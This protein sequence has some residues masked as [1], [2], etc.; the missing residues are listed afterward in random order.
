M[1][2]WNSR[3]L[4]APEWVLEFRF[5]Y[6]IENHMLFRRITDLDN[7]ELV[8]WKLL[9]MTK[10]PMEFDVKAESILRSMNE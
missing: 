8:K 7:N 2:V 4:R 1:S 6:K 10:N 5:Q 9:D 3:T